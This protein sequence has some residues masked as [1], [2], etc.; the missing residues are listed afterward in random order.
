MDDCPYEVFVDLVNAEDCPPG[1]RAIEYGHGLVLAHAI[2]QGPS[3]QCIAKDV[4][5]AD[6]L[7]A[8]KDIA[9][10]HGTY[11]RWYIGAVNVRFKA[12]QHNELADKLDEANLEIARLKKE[13]SA[14]E[15]LLAP[16]KE[17]EPELTKAEA[18]EPEKAAT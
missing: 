12:G 3:P 10:R 18:T 4:P 8:A 6:Y 14:A 11:T 16:K 17:P 1:A 9:L 5:L 15:E 2:R 7:R 13:L